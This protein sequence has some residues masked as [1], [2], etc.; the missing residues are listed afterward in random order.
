MLQEKR[1]LYYMNKTHTISI[2]LLFFARY[3]G[4]IVQQHLSR[5]HLK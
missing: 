1:H 2:S 5:E 4:H 3:P